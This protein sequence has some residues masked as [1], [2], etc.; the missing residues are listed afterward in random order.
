MLGNAFAYTP[1]EKKW[2]I[3]YERPCSREDEDLVP[4]C[5]VLRSHFYI[6]A[7]GMVAP[8]MAM[9][10][11]AF[12]DRFP[13]LRE[14]PLKEILR[15]SDFVRLCETTVGEIRKKNEKCRECPWLS[16]CSAGCR[17]EALRSTDDYFAADPTYC[18]FFERGWDRTIRVAAEPAFEK[19]MQREAAGHDS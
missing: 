19:Y 6:G 18:R 2:V 10:E 17:S 11:H 9:C 3:G 5:G 8:C 12:S 4:S 15:D 14:T 16:K 13:N 7:D 1:G